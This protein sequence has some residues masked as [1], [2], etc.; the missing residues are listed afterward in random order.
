MSSVEPNCRRERVAADL[1]DA[2]QRHALFSAAGSD[3][4]LMI[5]EG[6][7]MYL[8][9]ET[10]ESLT[11]E[12][13]TRSGI[14]YWMLDATSPELDRRLAED[15]RQE[16]Q[17]VRAENHLN[18]VEILDR[19]RQSGWNVN[20]HRSYTR[21]AM[22]VAAARIQSL[23]ASGEFNRPANEPPPPDDPSGVYLMERL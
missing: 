18:G 16:I 17:N 4:A 23:V 21:D 20:R 5:T 8:P 15:T 12:A 2:A 1:T 11:T 14:R 19:L 22:E 10:V 7:L 3:R 9:A 6:L 13:H